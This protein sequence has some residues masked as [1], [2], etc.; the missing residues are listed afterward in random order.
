MLWGE[1]RWIRL[2]DLRY[3][4]TIESKHN[5][6]ATHDSM[7]QTRTVRSVHITIPFQEFWFRG[8]DSFILYFG[9]EV[10]HKSPMKLFHTVRA[11]PHSTEGKDA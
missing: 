7:V 3:S 11:S 6:H 8:F 5:H 1:Q 9:I 4:S 2:R 10:M